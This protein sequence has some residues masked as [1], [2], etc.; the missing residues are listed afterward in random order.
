MHLKS[1]VK[2]AQRMRQGEGAEPWPS[3]SSAVTLLATMWH[4][5]FAGTNFCDFCDFFSNLQKYM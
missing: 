5:M 1:Q 2:R 4:K 3:V